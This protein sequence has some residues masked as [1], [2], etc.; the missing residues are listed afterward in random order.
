MKFCIVLKMNILK[1]YIL[2]R[3]DIKIINFMEKKNSR[4]I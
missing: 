1:P 4:N 2:M 3:I